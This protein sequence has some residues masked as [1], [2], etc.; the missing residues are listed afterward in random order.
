MQRK[1]RVLVVEDHES[2]RQWLSATLAN[3]GFE[4]IEAADGEAGLREAQQSRVSIVLLDLLL[5][6][7]DGLAVLTELRKTRPRLPV[8]IVTGRNSEEERVHGLRAGADDYIGK[9]FSGDELIARIEALLRRVERSPAIARIACGDTVVDIARR[10]V[11][12]GDERARLSQ[13]EVGILEWLASADRVVSREDL[14]AEVL[15]GVAAEGT[16]AIDMHVARLRQ[17]LAALTTDPDAEWITTVRGEGYM[18][19]RVRVTRR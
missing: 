3:S 14:L 12:R 2:V 11:V 16:R 17:K 4:P 19:G 9:P 15:G 1:R 7:M 18:L 5:P 10:E 8:I 6:K 13:A